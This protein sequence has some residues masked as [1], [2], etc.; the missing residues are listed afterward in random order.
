MKI[1]DLDKRVRDIYEDEVGVNTLR[2]WILEI[3]NE[4]DLRAKE[5]DSMT[6]K[7]LTEYIEWLEYLQEK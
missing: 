7:E 2:E 1:E 4:L 5:L 6:E 3:E